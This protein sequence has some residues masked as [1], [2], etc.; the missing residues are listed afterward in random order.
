MSPAADTRR[1]RR[2]EA[3]LGSLSSESDK[4]VQNLEKAVSELTHRIANLE[5]LS[6]SGDKFATTVAEL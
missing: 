1:I 5:S 4:A 3:E 6:A 2:L